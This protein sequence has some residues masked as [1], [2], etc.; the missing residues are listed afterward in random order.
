M[1][2]NTKTSL[3]RS[4]K[5]EIAHIIQDVE[6]E[7]KK[8]PDSPDSNRAELLLKQDREKESEKEKEHCVEELNSPSS[9]LRDVDIPIAEAEAVVVQ[10]EQDSEE[11]SDQAE[12]HLNTLKKAVTDFKVRKAAVSRRDSTSEAALMSR[13]QTIGLSKV[14]FTV[15]MLIV[16]FVLFSSGEVSGGFIASLFTA[17]L[18]PMVVT[19]GGWFVGDVLLKLFTNSPK[20]QKV[21]WW[22]LLGCG[23]VSGT[24]FTLIAMFAAYRGALDINAT[25]YI[26]LAVLTLGYLIYCALVFKWFKAPAANSEL[27]GILGELKKAEAAL[28]AF[29][30][31]A[32]ARLKECFVES[33]QRLDN[34]ESD[35]THQVALVRKAKAACKM[36]C[37]GYLTRVDG[38]RKKHETLLNLVRADLREGITS[39]KKLPAYIYRKADLTSEFSTS[40]NI[41]AIEKVASNHEADYKKL[42]ARLPDLHK[43]I[44]KLE[45]AAVK[46]LRAAFK[47]PANE[48][49]YYENITILE[50]AE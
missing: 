14:F 20:G 29:P 5:T 23:V 25:G 45:K 30:D 35:T 1:A 38:L 19:S 34:L 12:T 39:G 43:S 32:F 41:R 17:A 7:G 15:E 13:Q 21:R 33:H 9:F 40:F 4:I 44:Q 24:V 49:V 3:T 47:K 18:I 2:T 22:T 8:F 48:P 50:P 27:K 16:G 28:Q 11:I 26:P 42:R 36:I 46:R 6:V 31:R 37:A 10:V